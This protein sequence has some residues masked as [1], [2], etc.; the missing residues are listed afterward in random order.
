MII[1]DIYK[2]ATSEDFS[3]KVDVEISAVSFETLHFRRYR[4]S[5]DK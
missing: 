5:E 1:F 3:E 4:S 2:C